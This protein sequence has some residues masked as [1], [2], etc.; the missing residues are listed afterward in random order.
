MKNVYGRTGM[1]SNVTMSIKNGFPINHP[2]QDEYVCVCECSSGK[3][4]LRYSP[5]PPCSTKWWGWLAKF[6]QRCQTS[7]YAGDKKGAR[8]KGMTG[9][10][11]AVLEKKWPRNDIVG[12]CWWYLSLSLS[13]PLALSFGLRKGKFRKERIAV[14]NRHEIEVWIKNKWN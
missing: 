4:N 10:G 9:G 2:P 11:G 5:P 1:K 13:L 7:K 8:K 6:A 3:I 12:K 14:W